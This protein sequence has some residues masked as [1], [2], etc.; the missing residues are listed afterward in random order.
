MTEMISPGV[1][2]SPKPKVSES[3]PHSNNLELIGLLILCLNAFFLIGAFDVQGKW[4]IGR[5]ILWTL[6]PLLGTIGI[7]IIPPAFA[8]LGL[9]F[10]E[11]RKHR[12]LNGFAQYALLLCFL[13]LPFVNLLTRFEI[14]SFY[15]PSDGEKV[16]IFGASLGFA[17][18]ALFGPSGGMIALGVFAL[19]S[20]PPVSGYAPSEIM[21]SIV[22]F[23]GYTSRKYKGRDSKNDTVLH[24]KRTQK[25]DIV[26]QVNEE[27]FIPDSIPEEYI[28]PS[29]Y[30]PGLLP[31]PQDETLLVDE[32]TQQIQLDFHQMLRESSEFTFPST[33]LLNSPPTAMAE[34][35]KRYLATQIE[36]ALT[37]YGVQATVEDMIVGPVIIRCELKPA[38]GVRVNAIRSL[39]SELAMALSA[40][41]LR[42][43][44][45]IPG[46][47][48]MGIEFPNNKKRIVTLRELLEC[49]EFVKSK[50]LLTV[51]IGKDLAGQ[52]IVGDLSKMP[53]LLI[54]GQTGA[55]KS[56]CL[57]SIVMSLLFK[58]AP[59]EVKIILID[60]K[61]VE[62]N[63][64]ENLPHLLVPV[65]Q[66]WKD[67]K[68][69]LI[70]VAKEMA[71][72]LEK[73]KQSRCRDIA[74][75]NSKRP[76]GEF[77]PY[78]II[79]IDE[80]ATLMDL[81]S[82]REV[83]RLINH[84]A[85]L[86]RASGIH[87][88][89]ATQRPDVKV[90]TGSIK[91]NIPA[92]IAFSVPSQVDSRTI[93]DRSGA[94]LLLGEGDMLFRGPRDSSPRRAQGAFV[95][96]DEIERVVDYLLQQIEPQF[97]TAILE[98]QGEIDDLHG[99]APLDEDEEAAGFE[100]AEEDEMYFREAIKILLNKKRIS[101]SL[102]QRELRI[103][104]NR[105]SRIVDIMEERGMIS[106]WDGQR[107][108]KL[109]NPNSGGGGISDFIDDI[110]ED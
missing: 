70:W 56:V 85:R 72:R 88:I 13:L 22:R 28:E 23:A 106:G 63:L 65:V 32:G 45:P 12:L 38:P 90:I 1:R 5:M 47:D 49:D 100:N 77:M 24:K 97:N 78:I 68:N 2:R 83:E 84:L 35:D 81:S 86:A 46:R 102:L 10:L 94:D 59:D 33:D 4:L 25:L 41:S 11:H 71:A 109:I 99:I 104:Y 76:N 37:D 96:D 16:G 48:V 9:S 93:L 67:A 30:V 66:E 61:R 52:P 27:F 103:G 50:S 7:F 110:S 107:S 58:T 6:K 69:V 79:V 64:Y 87:L 101:A 95:S 92:R 53:H 60:P 43:E 54:A 21:S 73:L 8:L 91:A 14:G 3:T 74:T 15:H 55:G 44:A 40:K 62:M 19:F 75:F 98:D 20:L 31:I 57:N 18:K 39:R 89:L 42:I 26:E 80:F 51:C 108:R 105:A 34:E 17:F 29:K 82:G 36:K